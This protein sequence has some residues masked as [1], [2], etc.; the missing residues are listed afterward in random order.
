MQPQDD[1]QQVPVI[2]VL[3][4]TNLVGLFRKICGNLGTSWCNRR[5]FRNGVYL[6]AFV[7]GYR[8]AVAQWEINLMAGRFGPMRRA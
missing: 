1:K 5:G 7:D 4:T 2:R 3:I 6:L 8:G